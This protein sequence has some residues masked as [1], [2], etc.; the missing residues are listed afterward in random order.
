MDI[1]ISSIY[2]IYAQ[3]MHRK[4]SQ[5]LHLNLNLKRGFKLS[6]SKLKEGAESSARSEIRRER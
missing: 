1:V 6:A 4:L 3:D 2:I 5:H